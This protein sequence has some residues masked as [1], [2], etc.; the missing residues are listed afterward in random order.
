MHLCC[1]F[2]KRCITLF[3]TCLD[4]IYKK[5]ALFLSSNFSSD[6]EILFPDLFICLQLLVFIEVL[7]LKQLHIILWLFKFSRVEVIK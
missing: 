3:L 6:L 4:I 1:V 2:A 5:N 7:K